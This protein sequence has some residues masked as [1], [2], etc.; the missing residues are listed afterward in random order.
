M[1]DIEFGTPLLHPCGLLSLPPLIL[2]H[3]SGDGEVPRLLKVEIEI[4]VTS[5]CRTHMCENFDPSGPYIW[6][7]TQSIRENK[8][9][10]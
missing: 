5:L 6:E 8:L 10:Y 7:R 4:P 2:M 1:M 9:I 3:L